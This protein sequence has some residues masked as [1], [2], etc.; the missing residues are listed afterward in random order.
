[1]NEQRA[2]FNDVP[3]A[4]LCVQSAVPFVM[5]SEPSAVAAL[6]CLSLSSLG[7]FAIEQYA[8][9]DSSLAD[10][11]IYLAVPGDLI[12]A[13]PTGIRASGTDRSSN[14]FFRFIS[15]GK[16]KHRCSVQQHH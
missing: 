1:M 6:T 9:Q 5:Y 15:V 8:L 10:A 3:A 7:T 14:I 2:S 13:S 12:K 4:I 16:P 11:G